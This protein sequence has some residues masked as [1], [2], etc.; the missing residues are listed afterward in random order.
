[1]N[2]AAFDRLRVIRRE[3]E[4]DTGSSDVCQGPAGDTCIRLQIRRTACQK[5]YLSS[6]A[7]APA[8]LDQGVLEILLPYRDGALVSAWLRQEPDLARRRDACLSMAAHCI[9]E[10]T[11]PCVLAL[12]ARMENI[13]F[14]GDAA[15][16]QL[17]PDMSTWR[18]DMEPACDV[19]SVAALCREL[20]TA[21]YSKFQTSQFPL[22]L[23]MLC[24]RVESGGY[25][26][27]SQLQQDLSAIPDAL[28]PLAH[29]HRS[30]LRR[31]WK[32]ARRFWKP[33]ACIIVAVLLVAALLTLAGVYRAWR[34]EQQ[35]TWPGITVIGDQEIGAD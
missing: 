25:Q 33:A 3:Y 11:A 7:K 14:E 9:A 26:H 4:S 23:Q 32:R 10:K 31:T 34:M 5:A 30:L 35:D 15:W 1:M 16:L 21:G 2:R 12:S 17:L 29:P 22:E 28:M 20:L 8:R 18:G 13:R 27:W 6:G 19:A 24:A